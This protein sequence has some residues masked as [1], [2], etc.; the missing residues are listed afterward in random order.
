LPHPMPDSEP[1]WN[2]PAFHPDQRWSRRSVPKESRA[3]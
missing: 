2:R 3:A 1:A